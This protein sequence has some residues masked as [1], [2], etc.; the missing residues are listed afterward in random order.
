M[1]TFY[2]YVYL[3]IA[4]LFIPISIS[5]QDSGKTSNNLNAKVDVVFAQYDKPDSP[6]CALGVIKDGQLIYAR[7][8]GMANLEHNVP[9]G[10]KL[11]YDIGST[12]KQFTAASIV[13][14]A[15]QG[16]L[17]LDDDV[18]KYVSEL[19]TYQKPI[20]I[21]HLIHHTSGLRDYL[22][23]FSLAGVSFDDTT[24]EKDALDLIVRQKGLNFAPGDEWLYS[25]SGYFLLSMIVKRASG[26]SLAEFAKE[27]IFDPLG[28][29]HTIFLD[30]HKRIVPMRATG[31]SP[32]RSGFQI[33]MSN[34]EQTGDGA[35]MTSIEDLLLWDRNF[36]EPKV[37]GPEFL[38]QMH[39]AGALNK[40][41]KLDYASG[42]FVDE[43]QGLRRV[44]HGGSWAGY[45]SDFIRFPD[46][47]FSVIC[48]CNLGATNP[49]RLAM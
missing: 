25:N 31:Y 47:K 41:E 38:K 37:G 16:K 15:R 4:L 46:Q 30:H 48:L 43:H 22:T 33:E 32:G 9:N 19:S 35:V 27:N 45:R 23:L 3:S 6:G 13:L 34:F 17:S 39:E 21:R 14:L 28:M 10:P 49:S 24:T 1:R 36:Y 42:L 12:S 26:K 8:Y 5:A 2:R 18:R 20:T 7:G 44:S 40:G 11:V 29:K